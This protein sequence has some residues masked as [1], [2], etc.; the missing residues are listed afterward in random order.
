MK[1]LACA[2]AWRNFGIATNGFDGSLSAFVKAKFLFEVQGLQNTKDFQLIL[3][4]INRL[5]RIKK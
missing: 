4:Q 3:S 1:S 5:R 2:V